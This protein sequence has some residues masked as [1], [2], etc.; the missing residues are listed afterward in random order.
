MLKKQEVGEGWVLLDPF[1]ELRAFGLLLGIGGVR[2]V[3]ISVME[4]PVH[5]WVRLLT[6]I[7]RSVSLVPCGMRLMTCRFFG[8][9]TWK[10][11]KKCSQHIRGTR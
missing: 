5:P 4:E 9:W 7:L 6:M 10:I 1:L 3:G 11:L 2:S 8:F